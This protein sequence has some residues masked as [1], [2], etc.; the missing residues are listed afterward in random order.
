LLPHLSECLPGMTD[1]HMRLAAILEVI[2]IEDHVPPGWTQWFGRKRKDRK[3]L[4]RAYVA[5]V[6]YK[7]SDSKALRQ[8]L[9]VDE[10]L[11]RLCGWTY[12]GEVP[13]ES[14][15]SRAF[16]RFADTGLLDQVHASLVKTYISDGAVWHVSRDSTA[17]E[18]REK[19]SCK[20]KKAVAP[21]AQVKRGRPKKGEERPLKREKRLARQRKQTAEEALSELPCVCDVG[22]KMNAKGH[23]T[24]WIGYKF[25]LDVGDGGI[26][27][28]AVTT[29]ASV[30]DSQVAIPMAKVTAGR[31]TSWYDLMDSAYDAKDIREVCQELG[32]VPIIDVNRRRGKVPFVESDRV[33]RYQ[34][35]TTVERVNSRLKDD[36]GGRTVRVRGKP[37]VH[38]HLMFGVLV[39]F[40]EAL[41]GLL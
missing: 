9:Q 1:E 3:A 5:K 38:T 37:K 34:N 19:P 11:R 29:S 36:C 15:F 4:A 6:V 7:V 33:R 10:N 21:K 26:P 31:G 12:P 39:I 30:H 14:T 28:F 32:H 8:R 24:S 13:S 41:L 17:I 20:E 40:A 2:R 23:K 22:T 27:L 35:R 25:H 16:A 18:A